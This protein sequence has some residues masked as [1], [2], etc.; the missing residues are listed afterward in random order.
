VAEADWDAVT[1]TNLKSAIFLSQAVARHMLR[2]GG[3]KIIN[4]AS[5]LSFQGGIRVP[6]NTVSRSDPA[7]LTQILA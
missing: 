2:K 6:V 7:G 1:D 5:L 3:G 4:L